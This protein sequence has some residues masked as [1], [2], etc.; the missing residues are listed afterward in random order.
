M[1]D[2]L[3]N[4]ATALR[5]VTLLKRGT[6]IIFKNTFL[7]RTPLVG[8]SIVEEIPFQAQ[9]GFLCFCFDYP[10]ILAQDKFWKE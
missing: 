5:S 1:S 10:Q 8:A 3:F 2:S 4:N 7:Y 6:Q 9:L